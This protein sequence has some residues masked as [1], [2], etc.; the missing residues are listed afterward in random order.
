MF[1]DEGLGLRFRYQDKNKTAPAEERGL[2][3]ES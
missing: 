1:R 3:E 2:Q